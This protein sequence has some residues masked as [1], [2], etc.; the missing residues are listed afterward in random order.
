MS[1]CSRVCG[2][3][4]SS[5]ATISI[6]KSTPPTPASIVRT[7]RSW[8]GT[9]T[10]AI[11][12]VADCCVREPKLDGDAARLLFLQSIGIDAGERLN[13]RAL[14]VIDVTGGTDDEAGH[15]FFFCARSCLP[16]RCLRRG[17]ARPGRLRAAPSSAAGGCGRARALVTRLLEHVCSSARIDH[18][19]FH[20]H[21]R[22]LHPYVIAEP[23]ARWVVSPPACATPSTKR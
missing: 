3:T 23:V 10:N 22:D 13:Q 1:K 12:A 16:G 4:L 8:P 7:N 20:V 15:R 19:A 2:I 9:S 18:P 21:P 5:A 6:T 17:A 11:R 14:A